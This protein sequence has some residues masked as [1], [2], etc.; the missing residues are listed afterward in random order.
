MINC[1]WCAYWHDNENDTRGKCHRHP[2]SVALVPTQGVAGPTLQIVSYRP[3][4]IE[5]DGC[6]DGI[7]IDKRMPQTVLD[8]QRN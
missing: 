6:G 3:E 4:T 1:K 8:L 5:S 7:E 2:P